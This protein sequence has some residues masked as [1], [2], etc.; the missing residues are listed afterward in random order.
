MGSLNVYIDIFHLFMSST[1]E[2]LH[3]Y[4]I[5]NGFP[6]S[7]SS[8]PLRMGWGAAHDGKQKKKSWEGQDDVGKYDRREALPHATS[9][10]ESVVTLA[11]SVP[12]SIYRDCSSPEV[13]GMMS[14]LQAR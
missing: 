4:D 12:P 1:F 10:F 5:R 13:I 6:G 8:Q 11:G 9:Q 14:Q 2:V 7:T 3:G